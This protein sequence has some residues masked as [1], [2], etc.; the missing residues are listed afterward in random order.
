MMPFR[1]K[2]NPIGSADPAAASRPRGFHPGIRAWVIASLLIVSPGAFAPSAAGERLKYTMSV[3][4]FKFTTGSAAMI[5]ATYAP[6]VSPGE[7]RPLI[8]ALHYGG[9]ITA[10]TGREFAEILVLPA[11]KELGAVIV[12]PNCP[13]RGWTDPSSERALLELIAATRKKYAID[14][15]RVAV[16]GYSMGAVGVYRL[17]AHHPELFTA[18]IPVSGIPD[19]EDLQSIGSVPLYIIHGENDEVFPL[20]KASRA[21]KI[22]RKKN[23]AVRIKIVPGLS[24]Y[25]TAA[26]VPA[27]SRAAAWLKKTWRHP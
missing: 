7:P 27:L 21:F 24:H 26:Y 9:P 1:R 5:T 23:P 4:E 18:A 20:D 10:T 8:L 14:D 22:L 17:A 12:A 13:G 3:E 19:P 16:I 2:G 25:Q 15:R 6:S 11:L